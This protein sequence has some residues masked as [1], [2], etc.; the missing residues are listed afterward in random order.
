[1]SIALQLSSLDEELSEKITEKCLVQ[2]PKSQYVV[3][4]QPIECFA[5]NEEED[6]VY[7]PMGQ[8]KEFLDEFPDRKFSRTKV[9]CKKKLLTLET[10][11]KGYRDQDVIFKEA[12]EKLKTEHTVFLALPTGAGKTSLGNYISCHIKLKTAVLCHVDTVNDQWVEEFQLHSTAKVQRV[13][14]KKPIDPTADVYVIGVQKASTIPRDQL[15]DIGIVILDECHIATITA[16]SKTLL[17]FQPRYL[18]ALSATP[19][20]SDGM[21]KLFT[22][23]FGPKE[24][25]IHRFEV[26]PFVV[27]KVEVKYQPKIKY[28]RVKGRQVLDW[29]YAQSSMST[30]EEFIDE[31]VGDILENVDKRS[32][33]LGDRTGLCESLYA[34]I[35]ERVTEDVELLIGKAKKDKQ[36]HQ[37]LVAGMKKA[38]VG[39][40]DPTLEALFQ[41]SDTKNVR[42]F[43]GRIRTH[44]NIIYDYVFDNSTCEAH[45]KI[46]QRWYKR[47]GATIEIICRRD[48]TA[49]AEREIALT[50]RLVPGGGRKK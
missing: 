36:D 29:V 1:M 47:R 16:F 2:P 17:R 34:K 25:Y 41:V 23:N 6:S 7:V 10:D 22:L 30:N 26:K 50:R 9:K 11:T 3:D 5:V 32:M 42:Q 31:V 40:N 28:R 19:E 21:Q 44:N 46:R 39:F 12:L 13:K 38:G 8:W 35:Y 43:E 24:T 27:Y 20:R 18:I 49:A 45:W 33:V 4:P 37:I 48:S 14:G 15:K